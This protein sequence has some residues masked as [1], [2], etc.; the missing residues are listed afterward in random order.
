[1]YILFFVEI[2]QIDLNKLMRVGMITMDEKINVT[3]TMTGR[4]MARY[5]V[6]FET[7]KM[8]TQVYIFH[9]FYN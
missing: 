8:F 6:D 2:F 5:Y 3:P 1:M 9:I 7:M 4:L